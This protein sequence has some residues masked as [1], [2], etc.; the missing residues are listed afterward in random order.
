MQDPLAWEDPIWNDPDGGSVLLHGTLPT[1]VYPRS[2]RPRDT[3]HALG[4]IGNDEEEE[5]WRF[6]DESEKKSPGINLSEAMLGGGLTYLYLERLCLLEEIK[7]GRFPDP[8]PW[9]LLRLAEKHERPIFHLEPSFE[10][11]EWVE[12]LGEEADA[13]TRWKVLFK[14]LRQG[15]T[16]R[17]QL[18]SV[19]SATSP[20][21]SGAAE[22]QLASALAAVWWW[23]QEERLTEEVCAVRDTRIAARIRSAIAQ[24]RQQLGVESLLMVPILQARRADILKILEQGVEPEIAK[25]PSASELEEE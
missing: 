15:G 22:L 12:H 8:E 23:M 4:I 16:F 25:P 14:V 9:R 24:M 10:D 13:V 21:P 1:V 7:G 6:E 19:K 11:E 20:P 5:A 2:L 3:W 17:K 18:K